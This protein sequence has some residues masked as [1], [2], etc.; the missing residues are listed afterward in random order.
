MNKYL[1]YLFR[2]VF[3]I[4]IGYLLYETTL[5]NRGIKDWL[6]ARKERVRAF[7]QYEGALFEKQKIEEEVI[8]LKR[9]PRYLEEMVRIH[10]KKGNKG[11]IF[12]IF[13]EEKPAYK[14]DKVI[15]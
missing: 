4:L 6:K 7:A 5:G 15:R 1:K 10:T 14:D 12:Y 9:D 11:E 2:C 13:S 3:L 8:A